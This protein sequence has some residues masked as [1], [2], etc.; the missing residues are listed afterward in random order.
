MVIC[1]DAQNSRVILYKTQLYQR[2]QQH[3]LGRDWANGIKLEI[4]CSSNQR[5]S[6][7]YR[8][9]IHYIIAAINQQVTT[10]F[11]FVSFS[12]FPSFPSKNNNNSSKRFQ[13]HMSNTQQFEVWWFPLVFCKINEIKLKRKANVRKLF[14]LQNKWISKTGK[15]Q[16]ELN[17]RARFKHLMKLYH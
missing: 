8:L 16:R 13:R 1:W 4:R 5:I 17:V 11:N 10:L 9:H 15:L 2:G 3:N 12:V 14:V 6:S 7:V